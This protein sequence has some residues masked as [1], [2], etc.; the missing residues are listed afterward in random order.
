MQTETPVKHFEEDT[1]KPVRY[2]TLNKKRYNEIKSAV[3]ELLQ[4]E[5]ST[6]NVLAII[7]KIMKFDPNTKIYSE[8]VKRGV[9]NFRKKLKEKKTIRRC[10]ENC[11]LILFRT[12]VYAQP[13]IWRLFFCALNSYK[14]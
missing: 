8:A 13:P 2:C 7:R 9:A 14:N 5:Q 6:E 3:G 1:Q 12:G 4:D 11:S 10:S